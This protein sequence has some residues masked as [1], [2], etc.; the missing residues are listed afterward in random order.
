M[1]AAQSDMPAAYAGMPG[2]V[3]AHISLMS[4]VDNLRRDAEFEKTT[5]RKAQA[6]TLAA[7]IA[8]HTTA[9]WTPEEEEE[10]EP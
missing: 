2:A 5:T 9:D 8:G 3:Y 7:Q 4:W 1:R 6:A 10:E